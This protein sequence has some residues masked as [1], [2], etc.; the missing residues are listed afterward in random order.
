MLDAST[1]AQHFKL[2]ESCAG[3]LWYFC[4]TFQELNHHVDGSSP[5][6]TAFAGKYE[7]VFTMHTQSLEVVEAAERVWT[8]KR[9]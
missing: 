9:K 8:D 5:N 4:S 7:K 3:I 6:Y 1:V 2:N